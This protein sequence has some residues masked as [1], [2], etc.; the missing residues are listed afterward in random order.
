MFDPRASAYQ[1]A[2]FKVQSSKFKGSSSG[3]VPTPGRPLTRVRSSGFKAQSSSASSYA[4]FRLKY[5]LHRPGTFDEVAV[6]LG[7]SYFRMVGRGQRFGLS[8][9]GLA[10][11]A[12]LEHEEFPEFRE[13]WIGKPEP[14]TDTVTIYA[15]LDG[16]SVAG[17][18][19]FQIHPGGATTAEVK[20]ALF[21]RQA[22]EQVGIAP[23]TSMFWFGENTLNR[24]P[25][26]FQR[27]RGR[28]S[29]GLRTAAA[30][31]GLCQPSGPRSDLPSASQRVGGTDRPVAGGERSAGGDSHRDR[32]HG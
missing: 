32:G 1:G 23:L 5:P 26:A 18:Y 13:F 16:P 28:F 9:R 4:G 25:D 15:L 30:G 11:N 31:P 21:F 19:Q 8:A 7:A 27:V 22:A 10:L 2:K 14:E 24:P 29:P 12:G 17:A 20:A 3:K 6:F